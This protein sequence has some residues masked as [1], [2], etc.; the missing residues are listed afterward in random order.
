M[1]GDRR[2]LRMRRAGVLRQIDDLVR[3]RQLVKVGQ[4]RFDPDSKAASTVL[5]ADNRYHP[6]RK[7]APRRTGVTLPGK[8]SV[9]AGIAHHDGRAPKQ[10]DP[11][12]VA[13]PTNKIA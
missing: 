6:V 2:D 13:T 9:R 8:R 5:A 10:P 4:Y 1:L 3:R 11:P 7:T 12:Q